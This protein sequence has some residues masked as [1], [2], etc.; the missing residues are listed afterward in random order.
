MV[1]WWWILSLPVI[2]KA[3]VRAMGTRGQNTRVE[4]AISQNWGR[5][6]LTRLSSSRYRYTSETKTVSP[7]I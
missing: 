3:M 6:S 2:R 7:E 4:S 1:A 5:G